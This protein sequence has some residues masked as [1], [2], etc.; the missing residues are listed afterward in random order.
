[1]TSPHADHGF[2][3][4]AIHAGQEADVLV[5]VFRPQGLLGAKAVDRA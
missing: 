4:R 2:A 5:L 1:M 3:T